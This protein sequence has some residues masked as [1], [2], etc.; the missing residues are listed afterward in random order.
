MMSRMEIATGKEK[1]HAEGCGCSRGRWPRLIQGLA[2]STAAGVSAPG[3]NS[4]RD[5]DRRFAWPNEQFLLNDKISGH[6]K[7][8]SRPRVILERL[9]PRRAIGMNHVRRVT[10]RGKR[11]RP[12]GRLYMRIEPIHEDH[13]PRWRRRRSE[14]QPVITP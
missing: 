3:Y 1:T 13:T 7:L 14:Q 8:P 6:S 10:L 9:N 2:T 11:K 12:G 4:P 5:V